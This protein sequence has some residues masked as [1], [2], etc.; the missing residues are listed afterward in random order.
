MNFE[1]QFNL[2][3]K[4]NTKGGILEII[5]IIPEKEIGIP[6]FLSSGWASTP[7]L[8]KP[9]LKTISENNRRIITV[10]FK[11]FDRINT[12]NQKGVAREKLKSQAILETA[13]ILEI[14]K[15]D[16]ISHSEGA[17]YTTFAVEDNPSIFKNFLLIAPA[18]MIV[19]Q[20]FLETASKFILDTLLWP[21]KKLKKKSRPFYHIFQNTKFLLL[22]PIQSLQEGYGLSKVFIAKKISFII[23]KGVNVNLIYFNEDL[24]FSYEEVRKNAEIH[25][26][27]VYLVEGSHNFIYSKPDIF[28]SKIKGYIEE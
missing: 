24:I 10:D 12:K 21:V 28:W 7:E 17:V 26:I 9:L 5:D 18:G 22:N 8:L 2:R 6:V 1:S 14:E 23:K 27:P 16:I 11:K 3:K 13:K 15:M 25:N 20:S 19:G 4:I